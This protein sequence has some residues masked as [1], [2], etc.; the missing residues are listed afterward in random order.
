MIFV[1]TKRSADFIAAYVGE[2][3]QYKCTSIHED[4]LQRERETALAQF[5]SHQCNI[6]VATGVVA[7]GLDIKDIKHVINYD[8]PKSVDEYVHRIGRTGPCHFG[9][10]VLRFLRRQ[11]SGSG[12][13]ENPAASRAKCSRFLNG[14]WFRTRILF[15]RR[16]WR[17]RL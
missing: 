11:R 17:R 7:R 4:R 6:L 13:G 10:F 3:L 15:S 2:T 5:K 9:H 16:V 12:P 1:K 14:R 8:L